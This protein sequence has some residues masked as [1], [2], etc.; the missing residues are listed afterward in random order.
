MTAPAPRLPRP[1]L[2]TVL[3]LLFGSWGALYTSGVL[4][5]LIFLMY[6]ALLAMV[7]VSPTTS[8]LIVAL[9]SGAGAWAW[10]RLSLGERLPPALRRFDRLSLR[11][12][13][14]LGAVMVVALMLFT[15]TAFTV[16]NYGG[17]SMAPTLLSGDQ[18]SV[19]VAPALRGE[20]R[21]GDLVSFRSP[22]KNGPRSTIVSRVAGV[23][24]DRV[25]VRKG[26]LL[27]NGKVA[28]IPA[29]FSA[30][31]A[32]GCVD[33]ELFLNNLAVVDQSQ[34][35]PSA[36]LVVE[37]AVLLAPTPVPAGSV[38]VISD[39]RSD[40][41]MDS[42]SFGFLP[43]SSINGKLVAPRPDY[44][45]MRPEDCLPPTERRR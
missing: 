7:G 38:A 2:A 1:W 43:L 16:L 3:A 35:D 12:A 10:V 37:D 13:L 14:L 9:V 5:V 22:W 23:A 32:A 31:R 18:V 44:A 30:L 34:T 40:L 28:D 24:G 36:D 25:E 4:A 39:N 27:V 21:R 15:R 29:A 41:F 42:R 6:L 17:Y 11:Q 45:G 20:V 8:I 19:V 26:V 33:E